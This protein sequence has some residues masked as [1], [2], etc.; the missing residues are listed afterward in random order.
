MPVLVGY[1]IVHKRTDKTNYVVT[2]K[3]KNCMKSTSFAR[4]VNQTETKRFD[5]TKIALM[6][7]RGRSRFRSIVTVHKV[8]E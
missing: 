3:L 6:T 1:L 8:A 4:K 7:A 2:K 5:R